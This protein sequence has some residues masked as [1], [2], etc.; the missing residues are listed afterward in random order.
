[1]RADAN[2]TTRSPRFA[3]TADV[4]YPSSLGNEWAISAKRGERVVAFA[5]ALMDA[6]EA[7]TCVDVTR[8][9]AVGVSNG[10]GMAAPPTTVAHATKI[11]SAAGPAYTGADQAEKAPAQ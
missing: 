5:S 2:A 3:E 10:A 7:A 6:V 1:I 11:R 4:V 8:I 9:Y